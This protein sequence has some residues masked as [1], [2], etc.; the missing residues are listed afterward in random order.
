MLNNCLIE[1]YNADSIHN[2]PIF[3]PIH[4][5]IPRDPKTGVSG[6]VIVGSLWQIFHSQN[7]VPLYSVLSTYHV[8]AK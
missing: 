5:T 7:L 8:E 1:V 2:G 6:L 4:R 3:D